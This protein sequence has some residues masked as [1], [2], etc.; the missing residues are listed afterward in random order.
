MA[1]LRDQLQEALTV[2][3]A[4][5]VSGETGSGKTTQVSG[6]WFRRF[7]KQMVFWNEADS[8]VTNGSQLAVEAVMA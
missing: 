5:V 1:K 8:A 3:D 6:T 4:V 7:Q 2:S